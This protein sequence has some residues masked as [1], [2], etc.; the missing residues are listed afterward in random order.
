MSFVVT[1][2]FHHGKTFVVTNICQDK[3]VFVAKAHFCHMFCG[4]KHVFVMTNTCLL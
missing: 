2:I 1:N 3:H 4:D